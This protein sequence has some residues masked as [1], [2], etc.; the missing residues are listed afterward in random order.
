MTN[1][2]TI[3]DNQNPDFG[4]LF[5][6]SPGMYLVVAPD[7]TIVAVSEPYLEATVSKRES[8]IG[9]NILDV[10]PGEGAASELSD[11]LAS[12]LKNRASHRMDF[13]KFGRPQSGAES[14]DSAYHR[15]RNSPVLGLSGEVTHVIHQIE[16]VTEL[17]MLKQATVESARLLAELTAQNTK[18]EAEVERRTRASLIADEELQRA[19][20]AKKKKNG[21]MKRK[22]ERMPSPRS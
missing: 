14:V 20:V 10:F 3:A 21:P 15:P 6:L 5:Q 19:D 12:V 8:L 13:K 18:L 11:S 9:R 2:K 4:T 1:I 17:M 7:L 16:D 22:N